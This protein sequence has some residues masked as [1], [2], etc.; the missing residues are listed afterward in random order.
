MCD[1]VKVPCNGEPR[2][3]LVPKLTRWLG[4][5]RSGRRSKYAVSK[6]ATS[7]SMSFGRR[8]TRQRRNR[9]LRFLQHWALIRPS[10]F[11]LCLRCNVTIVIPKP[12]HRPGKCVLITERAQARRVYREMAA[13]TTGSKVEPPR[14][15]H[16]NE[17]SAGEKKDVV[18]RLP[19]HAG[20]RGRR[21]QRFVLA[22]LLPDIHPGKVASQDASP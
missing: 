13:Q 21:A 7:T 12:D 5:S 19:G 16:P 20:P 4:S 14:S 22:I 3:P 8:F 17:M 10:K 2:C 11:R 18:R 15:E 6:R 1:S 9:Q